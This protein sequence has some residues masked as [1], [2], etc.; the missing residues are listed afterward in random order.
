MSAVFK[1]YWRGSELVIKGKVPGPPEDRPYLQRIESTDSSILRFQLRH[2]GT[3][4]RTSACAPVP[5]LHRETHRVHRG[6]REIRIEMPND[7]VF[8]IRSTAQ[9]ARRKDGEPQ[10]RKENSNTD[11]AI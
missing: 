2:F 11:H 6:I 1:A 10:E 5:L 7:Q 8:A 9:K 4:L 3:M